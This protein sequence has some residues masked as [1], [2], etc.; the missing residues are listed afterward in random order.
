MPPKRDNSKMWYLYFMAFMFVGAF[1]A[2]GILFS[3]IYKQ[4][5]DQGGCGILLTEDQA[6]EYTET[7]TINR[8]KK[9]LIRL[10]SEFVPPPKSE[11]L[12]SIYNFVTNVKFDAIVM[13]IILIDNLVLSVDH[14]PMDTEHDTIW[15]SIR[16]GIMIL[17][18]TE[19]IVKLVAWRQYYFKTWRNWLD[20]IVAVTGISGIVFAVISIQI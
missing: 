12:L 1:G 20:F 4:F 8:S 13:L 9:S 17:I 16:S 11:C 10:E 14:H 19:M 2:M 6:K 5:Q 7:K 15:M 3:F 18:F